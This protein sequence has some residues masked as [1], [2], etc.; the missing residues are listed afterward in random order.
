VKLPL[1]HERFAVQAGSHESHC[2]KDRRS[3]R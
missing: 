2:Y 3:L 1:S